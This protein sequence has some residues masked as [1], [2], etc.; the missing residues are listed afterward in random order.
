MTRAN[1]IAAPSPTVPP[2]AADVAGDRQRRLRAVAQ[3][4]ESLMVSTLLRSM[5]STVPE[6]GL[7]ESGGATRQYRQMYDDELARAAANSGRGLGIA[8]MIVRS[9]GGD[10][11]A[12]APVSGAAPSDLE[13]AAD[14]D[15]WAL[16]LRPPTAAPPRAPDRLPVAAVPVALR[17]GAGT[18]AAP[19]APA[20]I[21]PVPPAAPR[22]LATYRAQA[23]ADAAD[24]PLAALRAAAAREG[25]AVADSLRRFEPEIVRASADTGVD[26]A[27][28]LSV[29][30][31]ESGGNPQ[32]RSS[33]GAVGLMQL[34]P[35]TAAEVG[36]SQP[37][38]PGQNVM[39]GARYLARMLQR[40]G[41][42][43]DLALAGYNAGPGTVERHGGTIP[44]YRETRAYVSSVGEL[45]ARLRT[46]GGTNLATDAAEPAPLPA[47]SERGDR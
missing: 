45:Y 8:D 2:R 4:F 23:A 18:T 17:A 14:P 38:H 32:A 28:L 12:P 30:V 7:I 20:S 29:L 13:T 44:P 10:A 35:G 39:G 3:E 40:F 25:G 9:Y 34:M 16:A 19:A 31:Q 6:S 33:R 43:V 46:G 1:G 11:A 21:A 26:P 36:V 27:L 42:S 37:L 47:E 41:S 24:G 5:R 22:A 15:D